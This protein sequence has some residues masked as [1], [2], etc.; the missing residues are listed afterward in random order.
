MAIGPVFTQDRA[1]GKHSVRERRC[2]LN[3]TISSAQN[4]LDTTQK[5]ERGHAVHDLKTLAVFRRK[6][7]EVCLGKE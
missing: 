4:S 5:C 3:K 6:P 2:R 7:T 1:V